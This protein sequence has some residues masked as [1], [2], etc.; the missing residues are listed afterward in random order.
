M[1]DGTFYKYLAFGEAICLVN[2]EVFEGYLTC[3]AAWL[4][5]GNSQKVTLSEVAFSPKS[6]KEA[7]VLVKTPVAKLLVPEEVRGP[8]GTLLGD[9]EDGPVRLNLELLST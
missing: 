6:T 7:P 8:N 9:G 2:C 1:A 5:A 3:G 4:N